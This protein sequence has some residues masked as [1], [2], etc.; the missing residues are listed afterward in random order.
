[1]PEISSRRPRPRFV[2]FAIVASLVLVGIAVATWC[3][4][5]LAAWLHARPEFAVDF[6]QI[7]L[8]P[9]PPAW[10]KGGAPALLARV[11]RESA[12]PE[13]VPALELD[14]GRLESALKLGSPWV[15][16]VEKVWRP[17]GKRLAV[18]LIYRE[19]VAVVP[20]KSTPILL[21]AGAIVVPIVEVDLAR[22]PVPP[23][24]ILR[25][26]PELEVREGLTL[27]AAATV[28]GTYSDEIPRAAASLA[29]FARDRRSGHSG[30]PV[31][32]VMVNKDGLWLELDGGTRVFWGRWLD[33]SPGDGRRWR[34]LV[35]WAQA[36]GS[37]CLKDPKKEFLYI[38][39]GGVE[40]LPILLLGSPG[41]GVSR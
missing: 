13:R 37:P 25:L 35:D 4:Q 17:G 34:A 27:R 39:A 18:R 21:T 6:D 33:P 22:L 41:P 19:P 8:D 30:L 3:G 16:R 12:L 14:L 32:K 24:P 23:M 28:D 7:T 29:A 2:R 20:Q 40:I 9:P 38:V 1:M 15:E 36:N 11:R 26:G 5:Y 10:L 31:D